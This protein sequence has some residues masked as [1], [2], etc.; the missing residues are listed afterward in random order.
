MSRI[1]V[2][3]AAVA[4]LAGGAAAEE[5]HRLSGTLSHA[6]VDDGVPAYFKL[7]GTEESCMDPGPVRYAGQAS[8]REGAAA[9]ALDGVAAGKYVACFFI[10]SDDNVMES[11]GPTSGDYGAMKAVTVDGETTVDVA[12]AEWV[13]IP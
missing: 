10:D 12:E 11:Q 4:A 13:R 6:G 2:A 7:I 1:F 8:F 9:Y 3:L 5:T